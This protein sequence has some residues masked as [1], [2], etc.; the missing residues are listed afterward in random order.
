MS[1]RAVIYARVSTDM[2]RENFSIPTQIAEC[3]NYANMRNYTILGEQFV[4]S[5]TGK[6]VAAGHPDAI[7][8]YV[9]DYTSR[10]LSRPS[11]DASL[12]YLENYGFDVLIVHAIDRLARDPYIRQTLEREF[13]SRGARVEFVLGDYDETPEGEVRKDLD[14]TFAKW[15]NAKRVER[16]L[17]G[18]RR[19]ARSGKWIHGMPPYGHAWKSIGV[20]HLDFNDDAIQANHCT[21]KNASQHKGILH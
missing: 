19:K 9:D 5:V 17:R 6:D 3:I 13:N 20:I 10:E 16:S 11:L 21:G 15:E 12:A 2:Q 7:P 8:A 4:D 14:A 1:K 18:K